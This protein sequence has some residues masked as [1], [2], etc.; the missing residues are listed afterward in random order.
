VKTRL[1]PTLADL[2]SVM[3]HVWRVNPGVELR[4]ITR[5]GVEVGDALRVIEAGASAGC[6]TF[7]WNVEPVEPEERG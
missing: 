3:D 1:I 4:L 5:S 2:A 7:W 6:K